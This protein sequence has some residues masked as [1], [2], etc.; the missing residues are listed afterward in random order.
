M[1]D[2]RDEL[3]NAFS[4]PDPVRRAQIQMLKPLPKRFYKDVTVGRDETG[5]HQILLDGRSVRTPARQPLTVPTASLAELVAE[6]WRAQA[7][8]IDPGAMPVTRLVN[9]ALDGVAK[10]V[11]G[12]F[13]DILAFSGTDMLCYRAAEP[14]GLVE[15]QTG[16]WD[17]V[18]RWAAETH[19]ARFILAEGIMHQA[20]PRPAIDAFAEALRAY[21][22]PLGLA[23]LHAMTTLTGSAILALAVADARLSAE[24]AWSL[25][26]L[27]EDWQIE[28][29]GT[30]EEAFQRREAR[31]KDM[32]AAAKVLGTL[33]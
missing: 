17:P 33:R 12:V 8:V 13:D 19:G 21:A 15:R 9:T 6:E 5:A 10:D 4:D 22:T 20:Q 26:H 1:T 11:R 28:H 27:D 23:C 30:D 16:R 25:A 29:W 18:L 3:A 32:Q 24:E 31:W 7:E 14:E 2:M